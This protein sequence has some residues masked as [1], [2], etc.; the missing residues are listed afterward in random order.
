MIGFY[1]AAGLLPTSIV[2]HLGTNGRAT[3]G[4]LDQMMQLAGPKRFVFFLTA[5]VPRVWEAEVNDTL[6]RGSTRFTNV[7]VLEWR[8]YSGCHD[9]WFNDGFH[10]TTRAS[11][12]RAFILSGIEGHPLVTCKK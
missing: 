11:G 6:H 12:V 4:A 2:V 7:H 9:D 3:D 10:L 1:N 8:D 5:R